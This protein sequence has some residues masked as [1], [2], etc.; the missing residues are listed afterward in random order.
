[1]GVSNNTIT[2]GI[3]KLDELKRI[4]FKLYDADFNIVPV[5]KEKKPLVS[6]SSTNRIQKD[7]FEKLLDKAEGIAVVGGSENP[8][9]KINTYLLIVDVD[10][11]SA[12]NKYPLLNQLIENT[13]RWYT[14]P[15]CPK[16]ENKHVETIEYG[17][18]FKC[19]NCGLEFTVDEAKRG[20]GAIFW[21]DESL[22]KKYLSGTRRF[23][24]IEFLVNNYA[25]IPPSLHPSGIRYEWIKPIDESPN[26]GIYS[27]DL[28]HIANELGF[29]NIDQWIVKKERETIELNDTALSQLV[30]VLKEVYKPGYRQNLI[31]YLAGLFAKAQIKPIHLVKIVK[32]LHDETN[33]EESLKTRLAP[34][35]YTYKKAG[36]DID[37]SKIEE[38]TG[39]KPYG[40]ENEIN[41]ERVK[42]ISGLYE[43]F[44]HQLGDKTKALEKVK[45]VSGIINTIWSE[46]LAE[47]LRK[48]TM[49]ERLRYIKER[50]QIILEVIGDEAD[51]REIA[52]N[53]SEFLMK[54]FDFVIVRST[55][56]M[57]ES[58][59]YAVD[60]NLLYSAEEIIN[61]VVGILIRN[62]K[63]GSNILKNNLLLAL[64]TTPKSVLWTDVNPYTLLH[65][66]NGIL[67]LN[68]LTI[69]KSVEGKYFT[70]KLPIRISQEEIDSIRNGNYDIT[71]NI[72]YKLFRNRFD[73]ENWDY[74]ID[75]MG[76][77]LAP[78]RFKLLV[79]LVGEPDA[80]KSTL[81]SI[82]TKPIEPII[83]HVS[84]STITNYTF[85]LES[86]I[87]RQINV[88]SERGSVVLRNIDKINIIVGENDVVEVPR[89]YKTSTSMYSLKTMIVS[90]NDPP[91]VTE[92]GGETFS[93]F[94]NRL[95]IVNMI[96]PENETPIKELVN[97]IEPLEAFKFLL[98]CRVQLEQRNWEV[99]KMD[100]EK[101]INYLL[102]AKNN[103]ITFINECVQ[104]VSYGYEYGTTL[105]ETYVK[106]C[107]SKGVNPMGRNEFYTT[108]A[109]KFQKITRD[110]QVA[111]SGVKIRESVKTGAL[112]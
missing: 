111:F 39:I 18:K 67:D 62:K 30:D 86:L 43:I 91:I 68:D 23:G 51:S 83:A 28:E 64:H 109:T 12:L 61:T 69:K 97:R 100:N 20:L 50:P 93:A 22:V 55:D 6:W 46:N 24:E 102:E 105:Y 49:Y 14:G 63:G 21:I 45:K 65:L 42:G 104:E 29:V 58:E 27:L 34:I 9:K 94:I 37:A 26:F 15:R 92:Y 11:P 96:K 99:R 19:E 101:I 10:K 70:Y 56:Q 5:D 103:A 13:V 78:Y 2:N 4:A 95:S 84:L 76:V 1:M 44:E 59:V 77:W 107:A 79:F 74:L 47:D 106:W 33:D 87:G 48:L 75:A 35:V 110:K 81:L 16:C 54:V 31:L 36:I 52:G 108:L 71:S 82:L 73:N 72:V 80:G 89:K 60:N 17:K 8:F 88:Y 25:L 66:E 98:W 85:G 38:I 57:R 3:N 40:L 53:V 32:T 90:M 7:E 41:V 112:G